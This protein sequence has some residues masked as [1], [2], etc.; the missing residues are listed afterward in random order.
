MDFVGGRSTSGT[1]VHDMSTQFTRYICICISVC[2]LRLHECLTVFLI[3]FVCF[4]FFYFVYV[5][6]A[7]GE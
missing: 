2:V 1:V 7:G 3:L 5:A 4:Y 6:T